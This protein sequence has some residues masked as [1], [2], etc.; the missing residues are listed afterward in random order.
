MNLYLFYC[1]LQNKSGQKVAVI[2][3]KASK[4]FRNLDSMEVK[5]K[6]IQNTRKKLKVDLI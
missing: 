6:S 1:F 2:S 4:D 5:R 3:T